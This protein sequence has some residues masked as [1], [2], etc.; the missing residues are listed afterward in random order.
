[1]GIMN[2][3]GV[4]LKN[5]FSKPVTKNYPAE[6]IDYPAGS[7]GHIEI[8]IQKCISCGACQMACPPGALKVDRAKRT[9]TIDRMDCVQCGYCTL[10]CPVKCLTLVPGYTTP[11]P[12]KVTETFQ[13]IMT[14]EEK[15]KAAELEAKKKAAVAAALAK[16]KAAEAAKN[17][18]A[19]A[20]NAAAP[21]GS[22]AASTAAPAG[23]SA[24][25]EKAA[26][27]AEAGK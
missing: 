1:M 13:H 4:M 27:A 6:P 14:E 10:K 21:A 20:G 17:A 19:P 7:R 22:S 9:W 2:F 8:D 5:L 26:P 25:A 23:T 24:A 15:K 16:K 11:D 18:A 3:T 12:T